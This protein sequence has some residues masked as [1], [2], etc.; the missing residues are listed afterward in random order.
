M[1]GL[2]CYPISFRSP[3]DDTNAVTGY[4]LCNYTHVT[5]CSVVAGPIFLFHKA[6]EG[7]R[8]D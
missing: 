3:E 7:G 6:R 2:E 5:F 1:D 4:R 8:S